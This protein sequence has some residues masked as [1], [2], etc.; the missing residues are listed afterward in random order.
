MNIKKLQETIE[1]IGKGLGPEDDWMPTLILENKKES[2]IFGFIGDSMGNEYAKDMVA[3]K[4]IALIA[5]FKPDTACWITTAWTLDFDKDKLRKD[6]RMEAFMQGKIRLKD[7]PDRIEIVNAYCYGV[8]GENEGEVLMMGY[9]KRFK[10]RHPEITK[11]KEM[12][13]TDDFT[14]KGRFPEAVHEGF[15]K[16]KGK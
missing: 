4:I 6:P 7:Q 1:K 3:G 16:A 10:N 15:R 9:I 8:R 5:E 2:S 14:A 11:W 13:G 12:G